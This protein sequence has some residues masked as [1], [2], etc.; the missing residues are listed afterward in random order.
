MKYFHWI[1]IV[2]LMFLVINVWA[3]GT[4]KG[5]PAVGGYLGQ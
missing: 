1:G 2:A 4:L 3:A 5:V